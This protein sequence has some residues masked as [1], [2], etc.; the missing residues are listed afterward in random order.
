[1]SRSSSLGLTGTL[2]VVVI[3][4]GAI[5]WSVTSDKANEKAASSICTELGYG[6]FAIGQYS[7]SDIYLCVDE[8]GV[9]RVPK[10]RGE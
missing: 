3:A 1:M 7:S 6:T 5:V 4:V 8:E 10:A 2:I 9:L